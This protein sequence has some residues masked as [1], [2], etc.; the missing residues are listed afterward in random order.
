MTVD[1]HAQ[2]ALFA[3][4]SLQHEVEAFFT[5]EVELLDE[6]RFDEWLD[7]LAEDVRYWMPIARNVAFDSPDSEYTR[8]RADANW[9]D[10]GKAD[11]RNRVLQIQ[12][13]DHWAEEPRS[14][15]THVVTNVRI[16]ELRDR[17][18]TVHSRFI[19]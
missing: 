11:L 6:R 2:N 4:L 1:A 17:E 15:T 18:M 14:R 10:E 5:K 8:E 12:G 3:Q 13:G 9:F 16:A 19:V 7:L